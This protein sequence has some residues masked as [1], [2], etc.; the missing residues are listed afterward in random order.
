[1]ESICTNLN[2]ANTLTPK[3]IAYLQTLF[4]KDDIEKEKVNQ[5]AI[6][7]PLFVYTH[8]EFKLSNR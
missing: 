2:N 5:I 7:L 3:L 6:G 4:D 8:D 1:L